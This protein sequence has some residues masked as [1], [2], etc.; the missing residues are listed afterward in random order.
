MKKTITMPVAVAAGL[1]LA[2]AAP[3]TASAHVS[4]DESTATAGGYALLTFKVPNESATAA[5]DRVVITLPEGL[6]YAAYVPTPGWTGVVGHDTVTF[7]ADEGSGIVE[8]Q[9]QLFHLS[10]GP[11]P[12]VDSVTL[13]VEQDYDDGTVVNWAGAPDADKPAPVLYVNAE[14][15]TE[16]HGHTDEGHAGPAAVEAS[17]TTGAG[18]D[19]LGRVLGIAGLVLGACALVVAVSRRRVR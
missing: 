17:A 18:T 11:V 5:T 12:D 15:P 7:Q 3:L 1:T 2:L 4:L 19:V 14:P 9:M 16:A 8:G 10:L 13:P 6:D